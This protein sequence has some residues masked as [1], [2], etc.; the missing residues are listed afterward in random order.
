MKILIAA[1]VAV[2]PLISRT[3]TLQEYLHLRSQAGIKASTALDQVQSAADGA[4][5]ELAGRIMG[6]FSI[7]S[8]SAFI[9]GGGG[10][11]QNIKSDSLPSWFN[12]GNIA[13]RVIVEVQG[14]DPNRSP[15]LRLVAAISEQEIGAWEARKRR[16]EDEARQAEEARKA[17][18]AERA[19]QP[20]SRHADRADW[21]P[22]EE[23][24][25]GYRDFIH[26]VNPKLTEAQAGDIARTLL[27]F[28]DKHGVDP[29][30]VVALV[31]VES[32]FRPAATSYKGAAGL[33]QL[34]PGTARGMGVSNPYD[35]KQNMSAT[36][37][38]IRGHLENNK[39][40]GTNFV[41]IEGLAKAM[42]SYNAG[43]GA[44]RKY[45]GV[46]P[47]KETQNYVKRVLSI[48]RQLCGG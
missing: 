16:A 21:R 44:V 40:P 9:L 2:L 4:T 41:S 8:D 10:I 37:R 5:I 13:I 15:D 22:I 17:E 42:A 48:Y 3:E 23:V 25:P 27:D 34:M 20:A 24:L 47:F 12:T 30:L 35:M 45:G 38:L 7:G 39:V 29:R 43:S 14:G 11:S 28:S 36:V 46:P 6:T 26:T 32:R 1:L 19:V 31:L 33:G 18:R